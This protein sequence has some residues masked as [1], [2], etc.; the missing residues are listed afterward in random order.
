VWPDAGAQLDALRE[1]LDRAVEWARETTDA[2][3]YAERVRAFLTER[4]DADTVA[5]Y[6]QGM[7]P[8]QLYP[9]ME[10]ALRRVPS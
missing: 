3:G 8:D 7:P 10:R 4:A 6:E 1:A 9:G 5:A 2:D